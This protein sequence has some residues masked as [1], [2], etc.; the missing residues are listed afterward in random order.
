MQGFLS[1]NFSVHVSVYE[2]TLDQ[3]LQDKNDSQNKSC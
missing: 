1:L 2:I 3:Q